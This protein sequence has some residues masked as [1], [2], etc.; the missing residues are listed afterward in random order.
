M[1]TQIYMGLNS[2]PTIGLG[3]EVEVLCGFYSSNLSLKKKLLRKIRL[4]YY[5]YSKYGK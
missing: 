5:K 1:F 2:K 3:L 4:M